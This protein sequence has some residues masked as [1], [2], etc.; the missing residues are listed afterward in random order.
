MVFGNELDFLNLGLL[1]WT[2]AALDQSQEVVAYR[3][4]E[5]FED[6]SLKLFRQ[7]RTFNPWNIVHPFVAFFFFMG[8]PI[9][10]AWRRKMPLWL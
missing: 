4:A 5:G 3:W 8:L 10:L 9:R 1:P 6:V 2:L 7:P